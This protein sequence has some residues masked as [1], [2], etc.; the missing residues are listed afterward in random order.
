MHL[1]E[2]NVA[3][4]SRIVDGSEYQWTCWDNGRFLNYE[5]EYA[6][7]S[8]VF[9]STNQVVYE[10]NI[11]SKQDEKSHRWLNPEYKD[12]YLK[13]AKER[14]V[15]PNIA[16]DEV[17]FVDLDVSEDWLEKANAIFNGR[18]YDSRIQVPLDLDDDILFQLCLEAHKHDITLNQMV[19]KVLREVID[20]H[21]A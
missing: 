2:V 9:N 7:V 14:N 4:D 1:N 12:A 19:E 6:D 13:E 20:K 10:A 15:D 18:P 5:S 16:Y 3:L 17:K 21:N 8:I 11:Y